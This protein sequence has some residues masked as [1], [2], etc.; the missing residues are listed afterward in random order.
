M[1][2]ELSKVSKIRLLHTGCIYDMAV[3]VIWSEN[4]PVALA[5]LSM[6]NQILKKDNALTPT[7]T[8]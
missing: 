5:K 3:G 8:N 1:S 7:F 6:W 2:G 4:T